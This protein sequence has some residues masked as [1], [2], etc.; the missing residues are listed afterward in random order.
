MQGGSKIHI[1]E[2]GVEGLQVL[3]SIIP[4]NI[5]ELNWA[6]MQGVSGADMQLRATQVRLF[7]ET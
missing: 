3:S 6:T 4:S 2:R 1:T 7:T 5:D